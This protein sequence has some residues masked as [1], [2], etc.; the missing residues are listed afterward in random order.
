[1]PIGSRATRR[2]RA[3]SPTQLRAPPNPL[4]RR[5]CR[6]YRQQ[7][8]HSPHAAGRARSRR[9]ECAR[10][11]ALG[12]A[13]ALR[14]VAPLGAVAPRR[15]AA[16]RR[17]P[18]PLRDGRGRIPFRG[19]GPGSPRGCG[20]G[21]NKRIVS[22]Q[23]NNVQQ[24]NRSKQRNEQRTWRSLSR[25]TS[26]P[27][28]SKLRE[29]SSGYT[30]PAPPGMLLPG[31]PRGRTNELRYKSVMPPTPPARTVFTTRS[32]RRRHTARASCPCRASHSMNALSVHLYPAHANRMRAHSRGS[33]SPTPRD[34]RFSLSTCAAVCSAATISSGSAALSCFARS[35]ARFCL[36]TCSHSA[37]RA[38]SSS[39]RPSVERP[40]RRSFSRSCSTPRAFFGG[41]RRPPAFAFTRHFVSGG[42]EAA[43]GEAARADDAAAAAA[44]AA[45][46]ARIE[47][48]VS[49]P[50]IGAIG[51]SSGPIAPSAPGPETGAGRC[52]ATTAGCAPYSSISSNDHPAR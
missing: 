14:R 45:S 18:P 30:V 19:T 9:R 12:R 24:K 50:H 31:L 8:C 22:K 36:S 5:R 49:V 2:A 20:A 6:R 52:S 47:S 44:A 42:G 25:I 35:S 26:K 4:S 3:R 33:H 7:R 32:V 11:R 16:S 1:M 43:G 29:P 23:K 51:A 46:A 34:A 38:T 48:A 40:L 41:R 37:T 17:R 27:S 39:L 21:V 28:S 13:P 15:G 10:R